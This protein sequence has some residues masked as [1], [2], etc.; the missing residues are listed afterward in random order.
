[1]AVIFRVIVFAIPTVLF[2]IAAYSAAAQQRGPSEER[3]GDILAVRLRQQGH[4]CDA[5]FAANQDAAHSKPDEAAWILKCAN[6]SYRIRLVPHMAAVIER[7][8]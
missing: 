8:H 6:A 1:M 5:P 3:P 2:A 4:R 7:L